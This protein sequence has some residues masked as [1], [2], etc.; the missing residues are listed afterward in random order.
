MPDAPG[1]QR[2]RPPPKRGRKT[3]PRVRPGHDPM[4]LQ[5]EQRHGLDGAAVDDAPGEDFPALGHGEA[6]HGLNA[7]GA[8]PAER[9]CAP[10]RT[11]APPPA[12]PPKWPLGLEEAV[13]IRQLGQVE[14]LEPVGKEAG[15][16]LV[17]R[18]MKGAAAKREMGAQGVKKGRA[19]SHAAFPSLSKIYG[20]SHGT[21]APCS[22]PIIA[23][24]PSK[25]QSP[26][27][28]GD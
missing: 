24:S 10:S 11:A 8:A 22:V 14:G 12:P 19:G 9:G 17:A 23:Q 20:R 28:A 15:R 6:Q 21:Y 7:Q 3:L 5:I 1:A 27:K 26:A 16:A 18:R 2:R 4:G 25:K 13:G